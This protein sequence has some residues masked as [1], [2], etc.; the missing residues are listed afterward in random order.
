M[1]FLKKSCVFLF[2]EKK[3]R[4]YITKISVGI[5]KWAVPML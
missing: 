5:D 3:K 2:K 1:I 4:L